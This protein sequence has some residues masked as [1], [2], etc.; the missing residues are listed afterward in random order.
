MHL[1]SCD[2]L[3]ADVRFRER[4]EEGRHRVIFRLLVLKHMYSVASS[5]Y[6]TRIACTLPVKTHVLRS[7]ESSSRSMSE[8][9]LL[10]S[11]A[12]SWYSTEV[13]LLYIA[14]FR[15]YVRHVSDVTGPRQHSPW[16]GTRRYSKCLRSI[17]YGRA[18][19]NI[20][21]GFWVPGTCT[22]SNSFSRIASRSQ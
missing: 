12:S 1:N 6:S 7:R 21:A 13:R 17:M 15:V 11:V 18:L 4:V 8:S 9:E 5:W 20:S 10:T 16:A 2:I 3:D 14:S 19:V 22:T